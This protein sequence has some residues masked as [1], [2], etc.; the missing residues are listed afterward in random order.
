MSNFT[1]H[2]RAKRWAKFLKNYINE[3]FHGLDF[4]LVYVGELQRN[5]EE[6]HGYSMTDAD[7]LKRMIQAV[8]V[9]PHDKAF[10]D[11]GCGKGMCLK[12]ASEMGFRKVAGLDLD[13]HLLDIAKKNMNKLKLDIECI[14]ANATEFDRYAEFDVFYFYHPFGRPVFE[15][16]IEKLKESQN[17]RNRDIWI[18]YYFPV[19][20][21]MFDDAGFE[22]R[23]Q[24]HDTT[25]DTVTNIYY[26]PKRNI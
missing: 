23:T 6:F 14:Y 3:R 13:Q 20:G 9:D 19:L 10:L 5:V 12:C 7:D 2:V 22:Q 18:I 11:V 15:K 17:V 24:I 26:Y 21:K 25:R 8:P 16:V 4:S 1:F